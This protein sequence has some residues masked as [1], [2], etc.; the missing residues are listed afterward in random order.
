M[1]NNPPEKKYPYMLQELFKEFKYTGV[2]KI[3]ILKYGL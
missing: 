3:E 2:S 1:E